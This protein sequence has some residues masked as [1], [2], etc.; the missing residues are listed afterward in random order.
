MKQRVIKFRPLEESDLEEILTWRNSPDVRKNM[1]TSHEISLDE[2]K[3]WFSSMSKDRSKEY[4]LAEL[5][6]EPAGVVGF[7]DINRIPGIA[8]WAFY[9]SPN[10]VRGTGSL[11]EYRALEH[12]FTEL[13]LH[14]LCCE[15]LGFNQPV[16]KL[17]SKFGFKVEG[18]HRDAFFN[19]T[20]YHDVVH[21]GIFSHEWKGIRNLM[22]DKLRV[23]EENE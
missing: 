16:V 20:E 1:Y 23:Y 9:A 19:G 5:N 21:L 4:F 22:K 3:S 17:H 7:T 12:A 6:G 10:A 14:K 8:S 15:V 13:D 2:H 18:T 11:M